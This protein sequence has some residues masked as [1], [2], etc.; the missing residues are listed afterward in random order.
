MHWRMSRI[1]TLCMHKAYSA[2]LHPSVFTH[3][4]G[5][6]TGSVQHRKPCFTCE[7]PLLNEDIKHRS[8]AITSAMRT[9]DINE[10]VLGHCGHV[11]QA[12]P[13]DAQQAHSVPDELRVISAPHA[14][15]RTGQRWVCHICLHCRLGA[16]C[17]G[18]SIYYSQLFTCSLQQVLE[19]ASVIISMLYPCSAHTS[20]CLILEAALWA[21]HV[22]K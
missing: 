15:L 10:V 3:L 14:D 19:T 9:H 8:L 21:R 6:R 13:A 17:T 20:M 12:A 7:A 4:P 2:A 16:C 1:A 18:S 5:R 22:C 11:R